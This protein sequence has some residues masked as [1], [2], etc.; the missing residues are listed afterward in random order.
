MQGE[1]YHEH[2][3]KITTNDLHSPHGSWASHVIAAKRV[4]GAP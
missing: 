4:V 3:T 1:G 2:I